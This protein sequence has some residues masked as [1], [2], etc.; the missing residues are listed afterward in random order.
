M[1]LRDPLREMHRQAEV[2]NMIASMSRETNQM[3]DVVAKRR[4]AQGYD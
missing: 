4:A 3:M 1:K 2:G